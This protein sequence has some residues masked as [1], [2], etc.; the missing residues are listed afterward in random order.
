MSVSDASRFYAALFDST[1][2]WNFSEVKYTEIFLEDQISMNDL[3][4]FNE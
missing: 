2:D 3:T 1:N 4:H